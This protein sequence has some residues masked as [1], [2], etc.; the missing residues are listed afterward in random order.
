MQSSLSKDM[1]LPQHR[2]QQKPKSRSRKIL[3]DNI[4]GIT[5]PAIA[6]LAH[7]AGIKAMSNEFYMDVR[8][9]LKAELERVIKDVTILIEYQRRRTVYRDD[10]IET[11]KRHGMAVLASGNE[12]KTKACKHYG[13]KREKET[14][15]ETDQ[16][17]KKRKAKRGN[18][19]LREI[20]FYQAQHDCVFFTKKG[21][22]RLV[23]E[24]TEDFKSDVRWGS[25]AIVLFQM[26]IEEKLR[27]VMGYAN[28]AAIHAGRQTVFP[29]DLTL[30]KAILYNRH[31]AV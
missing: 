22:Y 5:K 13:S 10:I 21:F 12:G 6:R 2:H 16:T 9:I 4:M 31:N 7:Y 3:R 18:L 19:A 29:S 11:L 15:S 8:E 1:S 20:K 17:R 14:K 23:R 24:V 26:N 30:V 28:L 25:D 27:K